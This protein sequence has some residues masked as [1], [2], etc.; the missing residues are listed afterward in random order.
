MTQPIDHT[1]PGAPLP[2]STSVLPEQVISAFGDYDHA[3]GGY[4]RLI[5]DNL[6]FS[7][8]IGEGECEFGIGI[9]DL[10]EA[11]STYTKRVGH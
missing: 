5:G 11:L 9:T 6:V 8:R 10:L 3:D 1:A 7:V 2:L 4:I